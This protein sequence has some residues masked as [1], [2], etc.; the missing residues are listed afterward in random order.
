MAIEIKPTQTG[1]T[2][3][4]MQKPLRLKAAADASNRTTRTDTVTVTSAPKILSKWKR[5]FEPSGSDEAAR[6]SI[7]EQ[8]QN[9]SFQID[10]AKI[11]EKLIHR[12]RN[13]FNRVS[14]PLISGVPY[15][16]I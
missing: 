14:A 11:A 8:V 1:V 15:E 3:S 12:N 16:S 5:N 13:C 9:G 10:V 6:C 2:Q 7:K 4:L